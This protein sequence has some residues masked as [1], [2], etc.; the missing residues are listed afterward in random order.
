MLENPVQKM[1]G[2]KKDLAAKKRAK[3]RVQKSLVRMPLLVPQLPD[4]SYQA[5]GLD[6]D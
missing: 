6:L 5:S 4:A 2:S 1:T 3:V